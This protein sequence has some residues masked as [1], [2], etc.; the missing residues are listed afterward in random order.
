MMG[1]RR[2]IACLLI[3]SCLC[4]APSAEGSEPAS[5]IS[6]HTLGETLCSLQWLCLPAKR[7]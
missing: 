7:R 5:H 4:A 1:F 3:A 2:L 6:P